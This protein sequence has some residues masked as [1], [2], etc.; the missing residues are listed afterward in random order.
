[1]TPPRSVW[2]SVFEGQL[3]R[4]PWKRRGIALLLLVVLAVLSIWPR[5][6][7][8]RAELMPD[9]SG[10]DLSS[11]LGGGGAGG[12]LSIGALLGNHQSIEAD[13]TIGR[14]QAVLADVVK[15]LNLTARPG[16]AN[17][18]A[19]QA[20]LR[21]KIDMAALRGSILQISVRDTDRFFAR[22]VV[23][24]FVVAIQDRLTA[25]NLNQT[26]Q[27]RAVATTRMNDAITRLS[28]AQDALSRFRSENKLA[29]P[30]AQLGEAVS[31]L[32][33]LQG[34][35]QAKQVQLAAL[36]EF[37]TRNNIQVRS[38]EAEI[39]GLKNQI[40]QA[41]ASPRVQQGSNLAGI[42][43]ISTTYLNLYRDEKFAEALYQIYSQ[44][45]EKLTIEELSANVTMDLIEPPY[46]DPA[47]QLNTLMVGLFALVFLLASLAEFYFWKPFSRSES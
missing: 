13:L 12:L 29:A 30:E 2:V 32:A 6:Y 4:D 5:H 28:K 37:A 25:L 42:A 15:R 19:A 22:N 33:N 26:A 44:A 17:L 10:G 41:Q 3:L 1:M 35:L 23:A 16:Y 21:K 46:V 24:A 45:L 38:I 34:Q 40:A 39:T 27:R 36:S 7:L 8:A 18:D 20:K 31:L 11:L 9:D 43:Q 47:R 14:S